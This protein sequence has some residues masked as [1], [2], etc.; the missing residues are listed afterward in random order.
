MTAL[1][2]KAQF[3]CS[4]PRGIIGS[5]F[6]FVTWNQRDSGVVDLGRGVRGGAG[7]GHGRWGV[8]CRQ[9][10]CSQ[11]S[12]LLVCSKGNREWEVRIHSKS[13]P[14]VAVGGS[15]CCGESSVGWAVY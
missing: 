1:A 10:L 8:R 2:F 11:A 13:L 9:G 12:D 3:H 4:C 6:Q 7:G 15:N 14:V 5:S